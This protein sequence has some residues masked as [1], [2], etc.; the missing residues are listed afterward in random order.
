MY[1]IKI[2][3]KDKDR[4]NVLEF[5]VECA[6]LKYKNNINLNVMKFD[7]AEWTATYYNDKIISL[8]GVRYEDQLQG[9]RLL[10][11]GATIP[12]HILKMSSDITKSSLQWKHIDY[13]IEITNKKGPYYLT[14]NLDSN[15]G[16]K[17]YKFNRIMK[18]LSLKSNIIIDRGEQLLYGVNQKIWEYNMNV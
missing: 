5:C 10:F 3:N 14:S 9:Y 8:S 17:S 6:F 16:V 7:S 4:V 13:Q 1:D 2:I 11:R 12:G 15:F 18:L